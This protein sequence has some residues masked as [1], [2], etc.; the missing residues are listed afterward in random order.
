MVKTIYELTDI[1]A[2]CPYFDNLEKRCKAFAVDSDFTGGLHY[3]LDFI[4]GDSY[5]RFWKTN[6][7]ACSELIEALQED[8][9]IIYC[10]GE[11]ITAR[12]DMCIYVDRLN[13]EWCESYYTEDYVNQNYY[14]CESCGEY[15]T[16][17]YFDTD[18]NMCEECAERYREENIIG[19]YH[20]NKG[21]FYHVGER[22][23]CIGIELEVENRAHALSNS[24][25]ARRLRD[26]Y[27]H[28]VFEHDG[29]LDNGFEII[30]QP[31]DL[32]AFSAVPWEELFS[33]L[34]E[35]GFR[36]HDTDTC[37]LHVHFALEWFG[38]TRTEQELTIDRICRFYIRNWHALSK[39]SRRK[40][41]RYC[42]IGES[43][44][45]PSVYET[46]SE[47]KYDR[48]VAVNICPMDYQGTIEFRLARGTLKASTFRAWIDLH[49]AIIE[50]AKRLE[51]DT[52]Y[53]WR[54]YI[55][56]ISP[57]TAEYI[58]SRLSEKDIL[59]VREVC[60]PIY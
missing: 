8:D 51:N 6:R 11:G 58:N 42:S 56:G 17:G 19:G 37:G 4:G 36:S 50:N 16:W 38:D 3:V 34:I 52:N 22:A 49:V 28:I 15:F 39:L 35:N 46:L 44:I 48:Y 1:C 30:S 21:E 53:N 25:M 41:F 26:M 27:P 2:S 13:G 5:D 33:D 60:K 59:T 24:D 57:E 12:G 43:Y 29:S 47:K 10:E 7:V 20:D 31:H 54:D 32:N 18:L 55:R 14:C 23:Q 9:S 45:T 40:R